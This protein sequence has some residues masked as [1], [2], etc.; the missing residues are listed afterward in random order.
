MVH[1]SLAITTPP[2]PKDVYD[3]ETRRWEDERYDL[4]HETSLSKE[5]YVKASDVSLNDNDEAFK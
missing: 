5:F 1:P 3:F 4:L 2:K